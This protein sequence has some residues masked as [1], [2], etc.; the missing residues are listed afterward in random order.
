M[1]LQRLT[2]TKQDDTFE[3]SYTTEHFLFIAFTAGFLF[4]DPYVY[5]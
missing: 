3:R 2:R 5:K 4:M 1:I